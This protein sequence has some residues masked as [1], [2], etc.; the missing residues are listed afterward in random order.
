MSQFLTGKELETAIYDI[1][2]DAEKNLLIVSPFIKLDDYF[3]KLFQ[4][5]QDN[6]ELHLILVFGKNEKDLN[7]SLN[8][9]DIDFFKSFPFV[10][11]IYVPNLHAKYY[12]NESKGMI[13]SINLYDYSFKNNIEFGVYAEHTFLS[14]FKKSADQ[15]AWSTCMDIAESHD[16]VFIKR[17][18]YERTKLIINLS[19]KYIKSEI[20]FDATEVFYEGNRNSVKDKKRL[21]DFPNELEFNT[22]KSDRPNREEFEKEI[23]KTT[24]QKIG[25]CI[26]TGVEIPFNI[27]KPLS[28]EAYCSWSKFS[29]PDYPE[30][31]CHYSG[32]LSNGETS[33][34]KPILKK[35]WKKASELFKRDYSY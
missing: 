2:W 20:I 10:S 27:E 9:N 13:T 23:P 11:I 19:K 33:V 8:K 17:P 34:N 4:K 30:K 12:G 14:Q 3:K 7:K 6:P 31:Y 24:G 1:I 21:N 25:Y 5:H 28:A 35:Y 15:D 32:E 29:N 16:V 18:V 22:T 26:R